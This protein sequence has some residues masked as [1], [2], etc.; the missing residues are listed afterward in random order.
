MSR[1]CNN[2]LSFKETLPLRRPEARS[3]RAL[4]A[5]ILSVALALPPTALAQSYA[6]GFAKYQKGDFRGAEAAFTQALTKSKAA[7]DQAK[8]LK[9]L[10]ISQFM[11]GNQNGAASSFARALNVQPNLRIENGE[12]LDEGVI[13]FFEKQ[14]TSVASTNKSPSSRNGK[15]AAPARET[16]AGSPTA[17][18]PKPAAMAKAPAAKESPL[19]RPAKQTT[20][21][22]QCNVSGAQVSIDG[23]L[24]GRPGEIF[25][26][27]PGTVPL[28][29][30]APGYLT[31][32]LKVTIT[33]D[34]ENAITINL[35]KIPPPPPPK[36]KTPPPVAVAVKAP[37]RVPSTAAV[38]QAGKPGV[39]RPPAKVAQRGGGKGPKSDDLFAPTPNDKTFYEPEMPP[40]AR[41]GPAAGF[42]GKDL[43]AEFE[44]D[45]AVATAPPMPVAPAYPQPYPQPYAQPAPA[46]PVYM[47]PPA[48][49]PYAPPQPYYGGYS[50]PMYAPPVYQYPPA[51]PPPTPDAGGGEVPPAPAPGFNDPAPLPDPANY[52]SEEDPYSQAPSRKGGPTLLTVLPLGIG[53]FTQRRYLMG[54][55]FLGGEAGLVGL[56]LY[57]MSVSAET[58]KNGEK[59]QKENECASRPEIEEDCLE[60]QKDFNNS[61]NQANQFMTYS[62]IG[63]GVLVFAGAIEALVRARD[64]IETK[65]NRKKNRDKKSKQRKYRGFTEDSPL[66]HE[67]P[68]TLWEREQDSNH[69]AFNWDIGFAT[70]PSQLSSTVQAQRL[71]ILS[72]TQTPSMTPYVILDMTWIF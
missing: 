68:Y 57:N 39:A 70:R 55:F 29:I 44:A 63:A 50:A 36:P 24:A 60:S 9:F 5:V 54:L 8:T 34:R 43:A 10:G 11:Q 31:K 56:G 69:S 58:K 6:V 14:R 30:A 61:I 35:E 18:Q 41:P 7:K 37:T 48:S 47:P 21:K 33:K 59:Y 52:G 12:V 20:L 22:V 53:Q 13:P 40:A 2:R 19:S 16:Q 67:S 1:H 23:I 27:D 42:G 26:T 45:T 4:V 15:R 62:F 71:G 3:L 66:L 32:K 49:Y 25:N 46:A 64:P 65:K 17:A 72:P 38:S 51:Y 28:E